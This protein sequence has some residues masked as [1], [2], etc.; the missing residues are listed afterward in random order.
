MWCTTYVC[1]RSQDVA[2]QCFRRF[3]DTWRPLLQLNWFVFQMSDHGG[4]VRWPSYGAIIVFPEKWNEGKG[5]GE[6]E[7]TSR[8]DDCFPLLARLILPA[9]EIVRL[10]HS[11][12]RSFCSGKASTTHSLSPPISCLLS[13]S[14]FS[15]LSF[16]L[17]FG[18][19]YVADNSWSEV[20]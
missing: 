17:S 19:Y 9:E 8:D 10:S 11:I 3:I 13:V 7:S 6:W 16:C 5:R 20:D 2:T 18:F 12:D 15:F 14:S 1:W 4:R